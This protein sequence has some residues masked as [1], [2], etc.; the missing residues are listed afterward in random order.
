MGNAE[1]PQHPVPLTVEQALGQAIAHH[2]AGRL[3]D[4]ERLYRIILK[5][6]PDQPDANH[7]LGVL[8]GQMGQ[9]E[10]G[11]PYLMT[12]LAINPFHER[13]S[14]SYTHALLATGQA[15]EALNT[16]RTAMQRGFNTPV[17]QA[18]RQ[19][20]EA[21]ALNNAAMDLAHAH[22]E[23][24]RLAALFNAGRHIEVENMARV[25]LEQYPDSGFVW[26]VLGA[27]LDEQGKAAL[28]ALQKAANLLPDDAEAHSNLGDALKNIGR[29]DDAV[30][31]CRR[32]LEIKP[33]LAEAHS[34]L[35]NALQELGRLDDAMA[36]YRKALEIKPG[37]NKAHSNL[38]INYN[39][40]PDQTP[41][42]MLAE[43]R[44]Y[45][46]MVARQARPYKMWGNV[47]DPARCLRVGLVSGD[48]RQH[49]VGNFLE[50]VLA[51]LS[52]HAAGRLEFHA[53]SNYSCTDAVAGRIKACCRGWQS[54]VGLSDETLAR[55]IREDGIDILLDLSGHTAFNRLPMFA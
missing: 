53:Y 13:Y 25:L 39:F 46:E 14:L 40:I 12:A 6:R 51:A 19:R 29:L 48:M 16:I 1:S 28:P 30:A 38:L 24:S 17:A 55:R 47:P 9:Y 41:A 49:P 36:S 34:N 20:A 18:L 54:A 42:S 22:V 26:K 15:K 37:F 52:E 7:N 2:Q 4:A 44:Q 32:A 10:A 3:Q 11:L 35:G 50:G 21:A 8:A 5:A 45:G 43:A 31:S 23:M 33:D 27:S